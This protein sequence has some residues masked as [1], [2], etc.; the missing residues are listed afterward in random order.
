MVYIFLN[1]QVVGTFYFRDFLED[2]IAKS[3]PYCIVRCG[4]RTA[5]NNEVYENLHNILD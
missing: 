2:L 1:F 3:D 4:P 5:P